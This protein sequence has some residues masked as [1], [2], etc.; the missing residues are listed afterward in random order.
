[1]FSKVVINYYR[2]D[3]LNVTNGFIEHVLPESTDESKD[4]QPD[5]SHR[6]DAWKRPREEDRRRGREPRKDFTK[7]PDPDEPEK[8]DEE[9]VGNLMAACYSM[10]EDDTVI[11]LDPCELIGLLC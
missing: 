11:T 6:M 4:K 5:R 10:G 7:A 2:T 3:L 9:A 1:M 8:L